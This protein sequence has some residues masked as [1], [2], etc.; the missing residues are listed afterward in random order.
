MAEVFTADNIYIG[1]PCHVGKSAVA[2]SVTATLGALGHDVAVV[3]DPVETAA[4]ER[5]VSFERI[6]TRR[7][8]VRAP[9]ICLEIIHRALDMMEERGDGVTI[10]NETPIA[11]LGY[12]TFHGFLACLTV[13]ERQELINRFINV[14]R[15][16]LHV[17]IQPWETHSN[18]M[19]AALNQ[20]I[21]PFATLC[22]RGVVV[23]AQED[24][25]QTIKVASALILQAMKGGG[26]VG[27]KLHD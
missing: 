6:V 26:R 12:C 22:K 4:N 24:R 8:F 17:F 10:Y 25:G 11:F 27:G 20:V 21:V 7:L 9:K 2:R 5:G 16:G 3:I 19:A 1:G 23:P 18:P 13:Q 15:N 14:G